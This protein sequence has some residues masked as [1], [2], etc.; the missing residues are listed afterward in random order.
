MQPTIR[1]LLTAFV[2][3]TALP[4][5]AQRTTVFDGSFDKSDIF[6][7]D[8]GDPAPL[9]MGIGG[10]TCLGTSHVSPGGATTPSPQDPAVLPATF[11]P[12][13][14][15][16]NYVAG[17]PPLPP[18]LIDG[19][20]N[21]CDVVNNF[22][23]VQAYLNQVLLDA[24]ARV[25]SMNQCML[26]VE[27]AYCDFV[28]TV[29]AATVVQNN[30]V[31]G[32][33]DPLY[34][35]NSICNQ[36]SPLGGF[37]DRC[38]RARDDIT[39]EIP[40]YFDDIDMELAFCEAVREDLVAVRATIPSELNQFEVP[41][42]LEFAD[43]Q[44]ASAQDNHDCLQDLHADLAD[45]VGSINLPYAQTGCDDCSGEP[46]LG[47]VLDTST[48]LDVGP[49]SGILLGI[50]SIFAATATIV[51]DVDL[52]ARYTLLAQNLGNIPAERVLRI[53][54]PSE[55]PGEAIML[56]LRDGALPDDGVSPLAV[57]LRLV[58][59][60]P[61]TSA[62]PLDRR[63]MRDAWRALS[64]AVDP[65]ATV[66]DLDDDDSDGVRD[67]FETQTG[68]FASHSDTGTSSDFVD[69]DGARFTDGAELF[70]GT[71]PNDLM[72]YPMAAL[73]TLPA[74]GPV[75]TTVMG[76]VVSGLGAAML[77]R[78]SRRTPHVD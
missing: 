64:R 27:Q 74:L 15:L 14:A 55:G 37:G 68:T 51:P 77:R 16:R 46:G 17:R 18:L 60:A 26:Q 36:L 49:D 44:L 12:S 38:E 32:L 21:D 78:R 23:Q 39:E 11:G 4:A 65:G 76:V 54:V 70:A 29:E 34:M 33:S 31:S 42:L 57:L 10:L 72:S 1:S 62:N 28:A 45:V 63:V 2:L 35:G 43:A 53:E 19:L 7:V 50:A 58:P 47:L 9:S 30:Y 52:A 5:H 20:L 75:A 22:A 59:V 8:L 67:S 66:A 56:G 25:T 3:L 69:S 71:D 24:N 41:D 61:G 13:N 6:V 40:S 73:A 48:I